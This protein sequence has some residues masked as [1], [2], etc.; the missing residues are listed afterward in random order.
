[1]HYLYSRQKRGFKLKAVSLELNN[2]HSVLRR[3][4]LHPPEGSQTVIKNAAFK[5]MEALKSSTK[6]STSAT[7]SKVPCRYYIL[8]G[9][10]D[11]DNCR[12]SHVE[13]THT[14]T[15]PPSSAQLLRREP[16][17]PHIPCRFYAEGRCRDGTSCRFFH[18][19]KS[20]TV[21]AIQKTPDIAGNDTR[22]Q[23]PCAFYL[24]GS[25]HNADHCPYFHD[26]STNEKSGMLEDQVGLS[27]GHQQVDFLIVRRRSGTQATIGY[28]S[29][30]VLL[31]SLQMGLMSSR[32]F[33][34]LIFPPSA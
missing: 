16:S 29:T 5:T 10:R 2:T 8:G 6:P 9:C 34:L 1:M 30:R 14:V 32:F 31:L 4:V 18:T 19:D 23:V 20:K 26:S 25:C 15:K 13:G 33:F 7:R 3:R 17:Q 21:F 22:S 27:P 11:G 24:K 28:D 12:F